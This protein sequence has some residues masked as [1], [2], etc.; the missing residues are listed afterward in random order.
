MSSLSNA[1]RFVTPQLIT[2]LQ[3]YYDYRKASF[4]LRRSYVVVVSDSVH[5]A[6]V[7][8]LSNIIL[9]AQFALRIYNVTMEINH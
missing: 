1:D 7:L 4:R 3:A 6:F 2:Y 8:F 5:G 9:Y